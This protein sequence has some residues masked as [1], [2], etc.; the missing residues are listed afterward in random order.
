MSATRR[1]LEAKQPEWQAERES[2]SKMAETLRHLTRELDQNKTYD[3]EKYKLAV[4]AAGDA[5]WA[6]TKAKYQL[7]RIDYLPDTAAA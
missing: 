1:L 2:L 7:D 5:A 3:P 4:K 6:V